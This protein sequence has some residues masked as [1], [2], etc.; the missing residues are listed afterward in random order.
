MAPAA[1]VAEQVADFTGMTRLVAEVLG[2]AAF[3]L[4]GHEWGGYTIDI[5]VA[6]FDM[7][8]ALCI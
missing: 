8:V 2:I 7:M 6:L 3:V 5:M 4:W 1:S